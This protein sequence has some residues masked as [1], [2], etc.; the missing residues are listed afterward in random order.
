MD[1]RQIQRELMLDDLL[2][3]QNPPVQTPAGSGTQNTGLDVEPIL[4]SL[5]FPDNDVTLAALKVKYS[6]DPQG[7]LKAAAE[8]R[9]AQATSPSP[10]T[11]TMLPQTSGTPVSTDSVNEVTSAYETELRK[12]PRGQTMAVSNLKAK[13]RA[14]AKEKGFILN[15]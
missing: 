10:S 4:K 1:E 11:A 2:Q 14:L 8:V 15:I 9:L 3:G 12:I 13:Y 5:Q 6:N 7:L